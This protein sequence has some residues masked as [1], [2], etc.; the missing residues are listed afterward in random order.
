MQLRLVGK[1]R[2]KLEETPIA[3]SSTL[4]LTNRYPFADARQI[5][6]GD[7]ASGVFSNP[8][9]ALGN[10]VIRVFLESLLPT[11]QLAQ[12]ALGAFRA[13]MLQDVTA[14]LM[15][16]TAR[17]NLYAAECLPVATRC[18]VHDAQV[19][20]KHVVNVLRRRF[21]YVTGRGKIE[22]TAMENQVR[23]ALLRCQQ[24]ALAFP[25]NKGDAFSAVHCPDRDYQPVHVPAQNTVIIGNGAVG[26]ES[27]LGVPVQFVG[28]GNAGNA[29]HHDLS[30][31]AK[32]GARLMVRQFVEAILP[33][34]F[35][36][37]STLT[38]SV[39][40]SVGRFHRLFER[41]KLPAC[42]KEFDLSHKFH[43]L[44]VAQDGSI[45]KYGRDRAHSSPPL[46]RGVSCASLR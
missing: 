28:V 12:A 8:D 32:G 31:Q 27:P 35:T 36:L 37:P 14:L 5:F 18:D 10:H 19:N 41:G 45:V 22:L 4:L 25:A 3:M 43:T 21:L 7:A 16:L 11:R 17:F 29:A 23:F 9:N 39:T 13:N 34:L 46:K 33:K 20:A 44:S 40:G 2:T 38:D 30:R 26:L 6:D 15:P 42:R 24:R 1:K